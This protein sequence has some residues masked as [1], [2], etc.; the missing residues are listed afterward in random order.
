MKQQRIITIYEPDP[1]EWTEISHFPE[2]GND[3]LR[4]RYVV[5]LKRNLETV[6]EVLRW[7]D[8]CS[9]G[10]EHSDR[11]RNAAKCRLDVDTAEKSAADRAETPPPSDTELELYDF[12][13]NTFC[14]CEP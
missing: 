13:I 5:V 11:V 7:M 4:V 3:V 2:V 9:T 10:R 8:V 1:A 14:R 6:A 12:A